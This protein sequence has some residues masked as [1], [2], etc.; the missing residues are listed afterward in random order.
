AIGRRLLIDLYR[1]RKHETLFDSIEENAA[2]LE[3]RVSRDAIPDD[4]AATRQIAARARATIDRLPEPQ[5]AAWQLVRDDG[6]S[7]AEA[8]QVLGTT[9]AAVKQRLFRAY[10]ALRAVVGIGAPDERERKDR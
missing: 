7:V 1:R 8:A 9:T 3:L 6:L 4:L 2:A 10:E 5:R